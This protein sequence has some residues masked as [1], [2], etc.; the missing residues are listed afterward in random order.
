MDGETLQ[1]NSV[2]ERTE[3]DAIVVR[4]EGSLWDQR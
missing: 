2:G 1:F 4:L 3:A